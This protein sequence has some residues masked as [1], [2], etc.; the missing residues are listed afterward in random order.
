MSDKTSS[1]SFVN[2]IFYL[3]LINNSLET[4]KRLYVSAFVV[5]DSPNGNSNNSSNN[6]LAQATPGKAKHLGENIID[7]SSSASM[8]MNVPEEPIT[9]DI[10]LYRKINEQNVVVGK[11]K[12]QLKLRYEIIAQHDSNKVISNDE[13]N[14]LPEMNFIK[15]FIWRLRLHVRSAVNL[16]SMNKMKLPS[17][18]IEGGWT[19]YVNG[20]LN[21]ADAIRTPCVEKN[22]HPIWNQELLYYPPENVSTV[23]GFFHILLKDRY[24]MTPLQKVIFPLS[25]FKPFHP[26]NLDLKF[27]VKD[28]IN[29]VSHLFISLTLEDAPATHLLEN[30]VNIIF[31][32]VHFNPIPSCTD[33]CAI[34]M[35]TN[36]TKPTNNSIFTEIDMSNNNNLRETLTYLKT[37]TPYTCFISNTITI[38]PKQTQNQYRALTNFILPRAIL[39]RDL[40]FYIFT[41]N[42]QSQSNHSMPN[43]LS[44]EINLSIDLLKKSYFSNQ[45]ETNQFTVT[46][47]NDTESNSASIYEGLKHNKTI[48]EITARPCEDKTTT[49]NDKNKNSNNKDTKK[50]YNEIK[51]QIIQNA[52]NHYTVNLSDV[53]E[54]EKWEVLSKELSQKQ[55]LIHRM[56]KEYEDKVSSLKVTGNEIIELRKQIKLL[57]SENEIL[58]KRLGQEEQTQI[59][60]VPSNEIH[61]MPLPE[62]KSKII[63]LAQAYRSEKMRNDEFDKAI[64]KAQNEITNAQEIVNELEQIQKVHEDDAGKFL[65]L[66]KETQKIGLY[67][68]T[69]KKQEE[70]I[71][72]MEDLLKKTLNDN[73]KQ[74]ESL[75]ELEQLREFNMKLQKELKEFVVMTTPGVLGKGNV[76][77]EKSKN[78][79]QRLQQLVDELKGILHNKKPISVEKEKL[80]NEIM[81]LEMKYQQSQDRVKSLEI[82]LEHNAKKNAK[83][84]S[85]LK[86]ILAEKQALIET[87]RIENAV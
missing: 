82:E 62:L 71:V 5:I 75:L 26:F 56:M 33:R 22:K 66:Q 40:T 61:K 17:A 31:T 76:E 84:I 78:E 32:N 18:Y 25:L 57:Q 21:Q 87:M 39:D 48:I 16:S 15:K 8:L 3:P 86:L 69:I 53:P 23:C 10:E 77:L 37:H 4:H 36:K 49:T 9:E 2:D 7:L 27:P 85:A 52:V 44:G 80:Q 41:R 50:D 14:K 58:R 12:L 64:K 20:D 81:H 43:S 45:H 1:P 54:K 42:S 83:E 55:E 34:I 46:W 19:M 60:C 28:S 13:M 63:S 29:D 73:E 70:V 30:Y 38:P 79:I 51:E 47:Y 59:E 67:R 68:E 74:K 72:K 35:T 24:T 6:V 11:L 65:A